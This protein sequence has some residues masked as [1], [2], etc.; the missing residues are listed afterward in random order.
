[1]IL[2]YNCENDFYLNVMFK[3][4]MSSNKGNTSYSCIPLPGS[5]MSG[6]AVVLRQSPS[7]WVDLRL[8]SVDTIKISELKGNNME[9]Y[10]V[11]HNA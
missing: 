3:H 5:H 9:N 1:M 11:W 10:R 8:T 2:Y 4:N 7:V 6:H